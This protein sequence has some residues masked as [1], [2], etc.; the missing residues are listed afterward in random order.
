MAS[1]LDVLLE[2]AEELFNSEDT[3]EIDL[4]STGQE[5]IDRTKLLQESLET[6]IASLKQRRDFDEIEDIIAKAAE[7]LI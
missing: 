1:E 4:K 7:V 3:N 2:N 6:C 5:L